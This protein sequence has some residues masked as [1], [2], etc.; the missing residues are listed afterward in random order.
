M[1]KLLI[2]PLIFAIGLHANITIGK[3]L[4]HVALDHKNGGYLSGKTWDSS[5]LKGKT[6]LLL[7]VDPDERDKGKNFNST[8]KKLE[9][10][11]DP[12]HFQIV[13]IMN[14]GATW[15][16]KTL[17]TKLMKSKMGDFP[18]RIIVVDNTSWLVKKWGLKNDEHDVLV[19]DKHT[20]ILFSHSGKLNNDHIKKIDTLIRSQAK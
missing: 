15:K 13:A 1:K 5:M 10:D 8:I 12:K 17:I 18:K 11:I 16:P 14:L 19:L 9:R 3:K 7:Y 20:K 4:P 2:L 6:T